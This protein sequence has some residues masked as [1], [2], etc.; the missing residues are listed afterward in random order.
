[1]NEEM[2]KII[3]PGNQGCVG[4]MHNAFFS[5]IL[6]HEKPKNAKNKY[7]TSLLHYLKF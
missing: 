3:D 5:L 4:F 7:A 2:A 6:P 1:M